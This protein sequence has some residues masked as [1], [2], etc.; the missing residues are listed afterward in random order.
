MEET[1]LSGV[2]NPSE[3]LLSIE[4]LQVSFFTDEGEVRS[5]EDVSLSLEPGCTLGVVGES[6]CGKSVTA[7]S[8]MRLVQNPGRIVGGDIH[9]RGRSLLALSEAEMR[10]I[11]GNEIS[12]IFQEPMT[13]LN[14]VH[15]IGKQIIESIRLHRRISHSDARAEAITLLRRVG[16]PSPELRIDDYPHHLSGGM[17]QRVMI[18]M[19]LA[20]DPKLLIADEPTTALDVTIQSQI[21]CL[22]EKLQQESAASMLLITHDLGVIAEVADEVAVMYL[23]RVVERAPVKTLFSDARHPYTVGLLKSMP[24]LDVAHERLWEIS[25]SV[26]GPFDQPVGCP[27]HPR[28]ERATNLCREQEPTQVVCGN[29]HTARC[30]HAD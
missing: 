22:F 29:K 12:M 24:L 23:G 14:P 21:L 19:A 15:A 30:W 18:A 13:S 28:C 16:I 20:G 25:G 2:L 9:F 26:P 1:E 10:H 11:R 5:V 4:S 7:L 3:P 8:I 27:F 17:R 6:G